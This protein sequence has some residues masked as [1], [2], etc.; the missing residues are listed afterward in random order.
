MPSK[1]K[2]LTKKEI[3]SF[4]KK[5]NTYYKNHSRTLPWRQISEPYHIL[6]SE[7]MLQ[8]TQ[9]DRVVDKYN[10]FI[11][12]F[13]T[14]KK[15]AK[16]PIE[17]V[18]KT[19]QGLGYKR[20][21]SMINKCAQIIINN[22]KGI[23]PD[24]IEEL[25]KLP[26][27]GKATA[28]SICVFAFHKQ[29]IFIETNIRTVFI[30][31]FFPNR[32]KITDNELIPLIKQTLDRRNPF[33]WYSALMD[34]GAYLK[35]KNPNPSRK[36]AHHTKQSRF[37]GSDRQIRGKILRL[38]LSKKRLSFKKMNSGLQVDPRR[39]KKILHR[40]LEEGFLKYYKKSYIIASDLTK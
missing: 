35:N 7:I 10:Q 28:A 36:S 32:K 1:N 39:L 25:Q 3:Q 37:E 14:I 18:L 23:I 38:L 21:A 11:R 31:E 15:L 26:G 2:R 8:Q 17:K 22:Y 19:W 24:N 16:A 29:L 34:Y 40:L 4:R 6:V 20:R 13:P 33:K 5:I 12:I 30:H 27:I 9:V